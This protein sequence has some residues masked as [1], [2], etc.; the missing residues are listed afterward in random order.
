MVAHEGDSNQH[1]R[2]S[3]PPAQATAGEAMD[4]D[5]LST[6]A[7]AVASPGPT[8]HG[9]AA[10]A[11]LE[12]AE[13]GAETDVVAGS[14]DAAAA[15]GMRP[16]R[17]ADLAAAGAVG[18]A[19]DGQMGNAPGV[20]EEGPREPVRRRWKMAMDKIST[21]TLP[22]CAASSTSSPFTCRPPLPLGLQH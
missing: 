3:R 19:E 17:P 15:A 4:L 10:E 22:S 14:S 5:G 13:H 7:G 6:A 20:D 8:M 16:P 11:L 9:P 1:A 21:F 2:L 18:T 12:G